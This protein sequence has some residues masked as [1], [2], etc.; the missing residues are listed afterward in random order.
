MKVKFQISVEMPPICHHA[1]SYA[2]RRPEPYTLNFA[3]NP[4]FYSRSVPTGYAQS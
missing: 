1:T 3:E 2:Q 4:L